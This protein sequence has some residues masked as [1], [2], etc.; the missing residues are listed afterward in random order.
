MGGGGG[1]GGF[2]L[3]NSDIQNP[4][5]R[6]I[7]TIVDPGGGLGWTMNLIGGETAANELEYK[8]SESVPKPDDPVVPKTPPDPAIAEA[9]LTE[10][11]RQEEMRKRKIRTKTLLSDQEETGTATVGTKTLLGG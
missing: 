8:G 11:Q 10:E 4:Y 2:N 1:L 6:G 7:L 3:F 9:K 5:A